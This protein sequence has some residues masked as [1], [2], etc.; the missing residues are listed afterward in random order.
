MKRKLWTRLLTGALAVAMILTMG[1]LQNASFAT[2]TAQAEEKTVEAGDADVGQSQT[3]IAEAFKLK[4]LSDLYEKKKLTLSGQGELAVEYNKTANGLLVKGTKADLANTVFTFTDSF[5]FSEGVIGRVNVDAMAAKGNKLSICFYLDEE[6]EPFAE[7]SLVNQKR[8]GKWTVKNQSISIYAEKITG[9]HRVSFRILQSDEQE[10]ASL[11]LR[12]VTFAKST[13]PV[14]YFDIDETQGSIDAMNHSQDHED[15][16]YGSVTIEIPDGYQCE[17]ADKDGNTDNLKTQTYE[18]EYIRGRGNSTWMA[19]KKPYKMKFS[20]KQDLFNMGKN[21]HWVLLADYYD[22]SHLRNKATYWIGQQLGMEYTPQGVFVD[23]V[24]NGEYY[25]SYMLCEQVRLDSERVDLDDLEKTPDATDEPTITG[26]YLLSMFPYGDETEKSF[27]T[28]RDNE[29]LI[30][31]PAFED[32]ENDAQYNYIKNYVQATEDA[33]YGTDFKNQGKSYKDYMDVDSAVKYYWM[34]EFS[35]N[36]DGFIST[37]TYLYKK[38]DGKLYW[39]PLW[40]FDYVAWGNNDYEYYGCEGWNHKE[41]TW[42]RQLFRDD[43]FADQA[44]EEWKNVRKQIQEVCRDGG[45]LDQYAEEIAYSMNYNADLYGN[46]Y[47]MELSTYTFDDNVEQLKQW[48]TKRMEWVD[49]NI[50]QLK[51]TYFTVTFK[52]GKNTVS[53]QKVFNGDTAVFPKVGAKS[54]CEFGGWYVTDEFGDSYPMDASNP[55][56]DNMTLNA[57]WIAKKDIKPISK[58]V[59]GYD[60]LTMWY[61]PDADWENIGYLPYGV[62]GGSELPGQVVW[63]TSNDKVIVPME[64]GQFKIVGLGTAVLTAASRDGKVKA[65]CTIRVVEN[66]EYIPAYDFELDK[67]KLQ[68]KAGDSVVLTAQV[69]PEDGADLEI[70]WFCSDENVTLEPIG[71]KCIVRGLEDGSA[72]ITAVAF[73]EEGILCRNCTV[74]VGAVKKEIKPGSKVTVKKLNYAVVSMTKTGGTLKVT[75]TSDKKLT[76]ISIPSTITIENKIYKVVYISKKAFA[77]NSKIKQVSIGSNVTSI[78]ESAFSGCKNLQ[79]VTFGKNVKSVGKRAFYK[80]G[81]LKAVTWKGSAAKKFGKQAFSKTA[82][83][84]SLTAKKADRKKYQK[85]MKKAG[86]KKVVIKA[87]AK[88]KTTAKK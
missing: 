83:K 67:T 65:G 82:S 14:M 30:E 28:S 8:E 68:M 39:G 66:Y 16:C 43:T 15:E 69:Y 87:S 50:S 71:R 24:M 46:N 60:N 51:A 20:K 64:D 9:E 33:I 58:I 62:I 21:K 53:T 44:I 41:S 40:D 25:G 77:G 37:S 72:Q 32:Y 13:I 38:R 81:K 5:D 85:L 35:A 4:K 34:Q 57:R 19:D 36:G 18:L 86:A 11:V 2:E 22:P 74:N 42:F 61:T 59:L 27:R 7:M 17:Y 49:E 10:Q 55:I 73:G 3:E 80:C 29:F 52:D 78:G 88:K 47:D 76:K 70:S 31:S 12:S 79:S 54:G 48:M 1:N 45:K 6:T 26:G 56:Y 75:G 84:I 23:V 63:S